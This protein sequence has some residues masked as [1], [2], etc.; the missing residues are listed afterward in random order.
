[1]DDQIESSYYVKS[2]EFI[3]L[4]LGKDLMRD[5]S[6]SK[7][8]KHA[9]QIKKGPI[10]VKSTKEPI[11]DKTVENSPVK[12]VNKVSAEGIVPGP[13]TKSTIEV[14][15]C[16]KGGRNICGKKSSLNKTS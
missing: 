13:L 15:K 11:V 3:N 8:L 6:S 7:L 16:H 1:M 10:Q 5:S 2:C 9:K 12:P 14:D 4:K